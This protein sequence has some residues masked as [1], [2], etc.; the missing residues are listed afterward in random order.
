ME[1][2]H[3]QMRLHA[4]P[5][6]RILHG[7][8]RIEVRLNDEKRRLLKVDD[9]IEFISRED[10]AKTFKARVVDLLYFKS[11][12][13][14]YDARPAEEFGGKGVAELLDAIYE[15]YS[16]EEEASGG[17]VGIRLEVRR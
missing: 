7:T 9:E 2:V 4:A 14:L 11:F 6:E 12:H 5:F 13:D 16:K 3:Y 15:Y 17:V 8:Q 1:P 10:A